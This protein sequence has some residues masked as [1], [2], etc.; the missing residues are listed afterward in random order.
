MIVIKLQIKCLKFLLTALLIPSKLPSVFFRLELMQCKLCKFTHAIESVLLKHYQ[1]HH[2]GATWPCI[3]TDCCCTFKTISALKSHLSRLRR[4]VQR[5]EN[6]TFKCWLCEY[7]DIC[8]KKKKNKKRKVLIHLHNHLRHK[9]IVCFPFEG[10]SFETNHL[11]SFTGHTSR[12]HK[13]HN[14]R[15]FLTPVRVLSDFQSNDTEQACNV[16]PE[17]GVSLTSIPRFDSTEKREPDCVHNVD[18]EILEHR[19]ASLCLRMQCLLHV[20][21]HAIQ[22]IID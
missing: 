19:L 8:C 18:S 12:N 7:N 6:L 4:T 14:L 13:K 10:C 2:R 1:L 17:A 15:D 11:N 5:Q 3:H 22:V 9:E 21:K 16:D 20:P